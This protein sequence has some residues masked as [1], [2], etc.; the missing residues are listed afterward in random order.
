[1][2]G[3]EE[4][5]AITADL[6]YTNGY[7]NTGLAEILSKCNLAKTSLYHHFG[8]KSG[9]GVAYLE[10]MKED[11]FNRIGLWVSKRKSLGEYLNKWIWYI[12]KSIKE[13]KFHGCPFASFSY[14]LSKEDAKVFAPKVEEISR[15]WIGILSD[16]IVGLQKKGIV[17][18]NLEARTIALDMLA[19][20]QGYVTLWKLTNEIR[21]IEMMDGKF[22]ELTRKVELPGR[23]KNS[24]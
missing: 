14:Q 15:Q 24:D 17:R 13:G 11:L 22:K 1:M 23:P 9:L 16:Y 8:S 3:K 12:N 21:Y 6:F 19:I 18:K 10:M 5:L 2:S 20:Y 7:N 4:I